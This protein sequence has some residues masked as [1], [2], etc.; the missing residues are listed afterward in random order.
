MGQLSWRDDAGNESVVQ[1]VDGRQK[2]EN[3]ASNKPTQDVVTLRI[4]GN[5][6]AS[7]AAI[8]QDIVVGYGTPDSDYDDYAEGTLY[9]DKENGNIHRKRG[10]ATLWE[11]MIGVVTGTGAP[12]LAN[13]DAGTIYVDTNAHNV[14]I[15]KQTDTNSWTAAL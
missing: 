7:G 9:F 1:L 15:C 11:K 3:I 13:C 4:P 5:K 2:S 6:R 10:D 14:Y 12:G 8:E